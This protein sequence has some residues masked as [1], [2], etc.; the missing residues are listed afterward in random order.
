MSFEIK[1]AQEYCDVCDK[2]Q[3]LF[4]KKQSKNINTIG[5]SKTILLCSTCASKYSLEV[6]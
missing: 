3:K 2:P 1:K 6:N 4:F 5:I